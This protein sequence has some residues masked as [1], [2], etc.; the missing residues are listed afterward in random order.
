MLRLIVFLTIVFT[1]VNL[2]VF[3]NTPNATTFSTDPGQATA[4]VTW[5]EPTVTD[6]SGTYTVTST[7][8]SGSSFDI[9]NTTVTYTVVDESGNEATYSFTITVTGRV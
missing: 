9:G 7:H 5:T 8:S 3:S 2:P 1:D 4:V 6:N